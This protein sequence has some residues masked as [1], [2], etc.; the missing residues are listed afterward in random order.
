[1]LI[2]SQTTKQ[3]SMKNNWSNN[4]LIRCPSDGVNVSNQPCTP[5]VPW[6]WLEFYNIFG[7]KR[8]LPM[9]GKLKMKGHSTMRQNHT[10]IIET[11]QQIIPVKKMLIIM[12]QSSRRHLLLLGNARS[13]IRILVQS[14]MIICIPGVLV[15][16]I[17]TVNSINK[18][19]IIKTLKAK[20]DNNP[21]KPDKSS[22]NYLLI[23]TVHLY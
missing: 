1:M 12:I 19:I 14:S 20:K 3:N 10:L 6:H 7:N 4:D 8:N 15:V 2:G 23:R 11:L 18:K 22:L 21:K 9:K 5:P 16:L 13:S 17:T